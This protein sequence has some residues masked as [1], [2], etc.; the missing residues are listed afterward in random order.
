MWW[1]GLVLGM[2]TVFSYRHVSLRSASNGSQACADGDIEAMF[3]A[4]KELLMCLIVCDGSSSGGIDVSCRRAL[5]SLHRLFTSYNVYRVTALQGSACASSSSPSVPAAASAA[6][7]SSCD[8]IA[9]VPVL[10]HAMFQA[11]NTAL[12]PASAACLATRAL[13]QKAIK[14][15]TLLKSQSLRPPSSPPQPLRSSLAALK[16]SS[17]V[18]EAVRVQVG[19]ALPRALSIT[20]SVFVSLPLF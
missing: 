7:S 12:Q 4:A 18:A 10:A 20:D 15:F 1:W 8:S 6:L 9:D 2:L 19:P 17:S 14:S 16:R 11:L 5:L 3:S 13:L